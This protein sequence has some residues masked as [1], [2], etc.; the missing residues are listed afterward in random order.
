MKKLELFDTTLR[1]GTQGEGVNVSIHDKLEITKRL[2]EFGINII[3]GGWPGSNPKDEEYFEKV[4]NLKL[5]NSKICAFGSTARY[6]DRI[7]SDN[8]LLKLVV[9]NAPI[10]T[11]F[12]K[13]WR[14]HSEKTLGLT[15]EQNEKLIYKSVKFLVE[16]GRRVIFDA[17]HFYDGYK[18]DENFAIKMCKAAV[19]G[20][21]DTIVLCDTNGGSLPHEVFDITENTI[22]QIEIPIGIHAHND[23]GVAVANSIAAVQAGAT[24]IQGT[25]NGVGERCGNADLCTIIPNLILKMKRE[26]I[27]ELDLK[28]LTSLSN[29]VFEMMNVSPNTRAPF[30]GKSAFAH[31]G[32]IHVSSV[33]KDS[34]MY[35][36]LEPNAVGNIQRVIV[37][38]LSGQSNIRYKAAKLGIELPDDQEF[39]K[40]FVHFL[41]DLEYKGFQFDG[42]EA[43]FELLLRNELNQ[44]PTYF[45]VV[46]A[47]VNVM[48]DDKGSEYSEAVLKVEVNGE[49]EH[50]AA[51][52]HG[53]VNALDKALHKALRRFY[54]KLDDVHL[55][56]Y[57]VRVL[58]EGDGTAAKVRVLIES[59]DKN[60]TWSTVGVSENIIQASLQALTDSIN[61]KLFK[62]N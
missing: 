10:I 2:D 21:A 35:E 48:F 26:T 6:P 3:E 15:D 22:K 39:N 51:E 49:I 31:K 17:E 56:D 4:Q 32:G 20:G 59:G 23:G 13:T 38:D 8:N 57:K 14:F 7:E 19:K 53:P 47:K 33:L 34:R 41:K 40:K 42:A 18:D 27:F 60:N 16:K 45:N 30:V 12:G 46:Y 43:S 54:S 28:N 25:M 61:Y 24:H 44:L 11:I 62:K 55:I 9:S 5:K 36:H 58:G 29:F 50:T 52:G 37:S 1:D